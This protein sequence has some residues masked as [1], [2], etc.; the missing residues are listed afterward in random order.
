KIRLATYEEACWPPAARHAFTRQ[1]TAVAALLILGLIVTRLA[2]R[3]GTGPAAAG[4]FYAVIPPDGMVG[5]LGAAG[6]P[7]PPALR[8]ARRRFATRLA[9]DTLPRGSRRH[10]LTTSVRDALTLRHLHGG[11]EDCTSAEESRGPWRRRFHH[12]TFYGFVLCFAST[13]VAA[14]YHVV[15]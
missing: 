12:A 1:R 7:L 3:G 15:L 13:T 9:I 8:A 2:A 5:L 10:V 6:L 11:G 14:I 4:D